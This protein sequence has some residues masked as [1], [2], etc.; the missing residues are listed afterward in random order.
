VPGSMQPAPGYR[1]RPLPTES[2]RWRCSLDAPLPIERSG[3][4]AWR[5]LGSGCE[6]VTT[7]RASSHLCLEYETVDGIVFPTRRRALGRDPQQ[8][9]PDCSASPGVEVTITDIRILNQRNIS[10]LGGS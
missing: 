2:L 8:E 3:R 7:E 1:L 10:A 6:G 4:W 9:E 5:V